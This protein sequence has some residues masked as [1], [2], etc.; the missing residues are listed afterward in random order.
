MKLRASNTV[1]ACALLAV[2]A[3]LGLA[4]L[5]FNAFWDDEAQVAFFA[6]NLVKNG[7]LSGWDGR[8]LFAQNN[9]GILDQYMRSINSQLDY[10]VCAASFRLFGFGTFAGRFPFVLIGLAYLAV[11][12]LLLREEFGPGSRLPL[13]AL[14]L[15]G[16]SYSFFLNARQCRYYSLI[17]LFTVALLLAYRR[18]LRLKRRRDLAVL[19]A[20]AA[21]LFYSHYLMG[22]CMLLSLG[23]VHLLFHRKAT[24]PAMWKAFAVTIGAFCLAILPF[25][26]GRKLWVRP[27]APTFAPFL[28]A[29]S[30]LLLWNFRDL[31]TVAFLPGFAVIGLA[32]FYLRYRR[33]DFF[34]A[35]KTAQ[36]AALTA[37]YV[38]FLS[39]FSIQPGKWYGW[40]GGLADIRYLLTVLPLCG[41]LL[42]VFVSTVE[43]GLGTA[44][45]LAVTAVMLCTN[46]LCFNFGGGR[47]QWLLPAYVREA[48]VD[49]TTP[50]EAAVNFVNE[51][52]AQ[53][54]I[55]YTAPEYCAYTIMY[56]CGDKVK[57]G[58]LLH[59]NTRLDRTAVEAF[60]PHLFD[61]AV[62]PD[63]VLCFGMSKSGFERLAHFSRDRYTYGCDTQQQCSYDRRLGSFWRDRTRPELPWHSFGAD[64]D[65]DPDSQDIYAFRRRERA[66]MAE[67]R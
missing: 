24:T 4:G 63:W 36:Y 30:N 58:G 33:S 5:G 19:G 39:L 13:Y 51:H 22:G 55:V 16:L 48:H 38:V 11:F 1:I 49:Y 25:V 27:D 14:A 21:G 64:T 60:A 15:T 67:G 18:Y 57:L 32:A 44:A 10:L 17:L 41:V 20:A 52:A 35:S 47:F 6:K 42:A 34:P 8:N 59:P 28:E 12:W 37:F 23:C 54:D 2:I 29:R 56:Y 65:Y 53:D 43:R 46:M 61:D 40:A 45:A 9:G 62:Y 50:F 3:Y 7:T 66:G 26:I 31:D